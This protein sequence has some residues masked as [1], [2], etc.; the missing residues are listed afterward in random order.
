MQSW[1]PWANQEESGHQLL[2]FQSTH[3]TRQQVLLG[4]LSS[5]TLER[6]FS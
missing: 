3:V 4:A 5:I 1:G 2:D 6:V